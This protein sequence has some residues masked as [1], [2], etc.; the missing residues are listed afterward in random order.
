MSDW[1]IET[2]NL[3]KIYSNRNI[4]LNGANLKVPRAATFALVGPNGSGKTTTIR[5]L[6]GLHTPT[7]GS[8]KVFGE[9]MTPK[10]VHLRQRIGYLPTNPK[11]PSDL[12]PIMYLDFVGKLFGMPSEQRKPRL[13]SLLRAVGLLGASSQ[14]IKNLSTGMTTR[15]GIAASLMNDPDLL[16]WDEPTSGL[17]PEGRKY[18]LDLI[19]ELSKVKTVVVSSH[20]LADLEKVCDHVGIISDGRLI[21]NGPLSDM[22]RFTRSNTLEI[23][24]A[25]LPADLVKSLR[26]LPFIENVEQ[27]GLKLWLG[28]EGGQVLADGMAQVLQQ[29]AARGVALVG[30]RS[31][32]NEMV[33]AF[34]RLLEEERAHGF[35]RILENNAFSGLDSRRPDDADPLMGGAAVAAGGGGSDAD[36]P[37]RGGLDL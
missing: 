20:D 12:N 22:K 2:Q 24:L 34:I 36:N 31:L 17:D 27:R 35:S 8:A 3:T 28:F 16:I 37:D 7:A 21:F 26:A 6:L 23:E 18:T 10:A 19:K 14:K 25:E 32:E 30:V 1:V 4:A 5:L 11:F 9:E 33:D 29:V 13:S 15:L